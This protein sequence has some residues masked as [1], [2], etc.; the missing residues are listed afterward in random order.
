MIPSF[1]AAGEFLHDYSSLRVVASVFSH[2]YSSILLVNHRYSC[3]AY[4]R[5][6]HEY[7]RYVR[8]IYHNM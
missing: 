6:L 4:Q 5:Q 2:I 7:L 1:N 3:R 8:I